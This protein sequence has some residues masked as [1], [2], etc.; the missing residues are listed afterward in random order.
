[1]PFNSSLLSSLVILMF[2][3]SGMSTER[4][5][6]VCT[7]GHAAPDRDVQHHLS[8]FLWFLGLPKP[9]HF[10]KW[11]KTTSLFARKTQNYFI[12]LIINC[13]VLQLKPKT[14][15]QKH[16]LFSCHTVYR[17]YKW[18]ELIAPFPTALLASS[19]PLCLSPAAHGVLPWRRTTLREQISPLRLKLL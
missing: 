12:Y 15:H 17:V 9:W 11:R 6:L 7:A 19:D 4:W 8:I 10:S 2:L 18:K 13:L 16:Q 3:H 14:T 5:C 1:M